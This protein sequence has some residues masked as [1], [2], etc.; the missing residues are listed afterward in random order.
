MENI[1][2][3]PEGER[4]SNYDIKGYLGKNDLRTFKQLSILQQSCKWPHLLKRDI[5]EK[6]NVQSG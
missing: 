6:I 3:E 2:S 5:I 1:F 4:I